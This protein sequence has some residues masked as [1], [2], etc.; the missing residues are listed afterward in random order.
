MGGTHE[1]GEK[2]GPSGVARTAEEPGQTANVDLCFV[3]V[4][5]AAQQRLPAVSGSSGRLVVAPVRETEEEQSWPGQ[6]FE[7]PD[8]VLSIRP[9][10]R[11]RSEKAVRPRAAGR[12]AQTGAR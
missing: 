10:R 7:D 4:T 11:S 6:I 2:R 12:P 1:R 3:P 8:G 5:H 9:G